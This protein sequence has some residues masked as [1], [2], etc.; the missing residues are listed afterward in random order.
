[1]I[2]LCHPTMH[3]ERQTQCTHHIHTKKGR[4]FILRANEARMVVA[5]GGAVA[6]RFSKYEF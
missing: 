2:N 1:M 3:D 4:A 6:P 5:T